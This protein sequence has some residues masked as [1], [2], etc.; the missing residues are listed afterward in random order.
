MK[1]YI[2]LL[3]LLIVS[4]LSFGQEDAYHNKRPNTLL[5]FK[6]ITDYYESVNKQNGS[7]SEVNTYASTNG[8]LIL[9]E[10]GEKSRKIAD[11]KLNWL[12]LIFKSIN[13]PQKASDLFE[14]EVL[15]NT[16]NGKYWLPIQKQLFGFWE[17]EMKLNKKALIYIRTF[18]SLKGEEENKFLF[19]INSFS[20]NFYDGLW[21][22]A[23]K[24]YDVKDDI[25]ANSIV[26]KLIELDPKDGRN[27]A[28]YGFHY[29]D[30]GYPDNRPLLQK[31]DSLFSIAEKLSPDYSYGHYQW[32][33]VKF[34]LGEYVKAWEALDK[35]RSLGETNIEGYILERFEGK[36]PYAEYLKGKK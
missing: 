32:A 18:G 23:I 31:A 10:S 4:S 33:L 13:I 20:G 2:S 12:N 25:N 36:L 24:S 30:K 21:E 7:K 29:Y 27:Y 11:E 9:I 22:E 5:D 35:A 34:Q 8:Y 26:K 6:V 15:I 17:E 3:L 19:T 28:M 16:D 1:T 14:H